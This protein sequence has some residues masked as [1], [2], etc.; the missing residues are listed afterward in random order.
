MAIV[1][2]ILGAAALTSAGS[3]SGQVTIKEKKT[4]P[5]A[6]LSETVVYLRGAKT[7]PR[8]VHAAMVMKGKLF[9]PRVLIV[10]T[11]SV[12]DFPNEDPVFHNVFSL[13]TENHFDLDLYKRPVSKSFIFE[14]P[15]VAR[16]YCNIHPQMSGVV[17]VVDSSYFARV[18]S[19]GAFTLDSV[20]Q[21]SYTLA[22]WHERGGESSVVVNVPA[23]G[24]ARADLT[25]DAIRYRRQSHLDKFGKDYSTHDASAY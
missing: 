14:H 10:P 15:G 17:I 16:V 12:V 24:Q 2:M 6:D 9:S 4:G 20:P 18:D 22:A 23:E 8:P 19:N 5:S 7:K 21:G 25:L 11:G 3:L 13:S 1:S